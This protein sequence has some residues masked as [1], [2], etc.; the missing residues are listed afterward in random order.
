[1]K[2]HRIFTPGPTEVVPRV[3]EAM[4]RPIMHHRSGQF[5]DLHRR[6][7]DELKYVYRTANPIVVLTASG[8]GAMEATIASLTLPGERVLV[9]RCGKFSARWA[10]VAGVY[11][12]DV[13][14]LD[15]PWG[16]TIAAERLEEALEESGD[17]A[18]VFT[19]HCE[20]STGVLMDVEGIAAASRR[21]GAM[22]VVDAITGLCAEEL[23]TDS[24][25]LDVVIGGSQKGFGVPPGLSFVS[26]SARARERLER[27]AH[28]VYYLDLGKALESQEKWDTPYTPSTVLFVALS[29]SLAMIRSEGL[30]NTVRRHGRNAAAVRS[31]VKALGLEL[32]ASVPANAVTT[33]LPPE[34]MAGRIA[35]TMA[36][37]YGIRIAQGQ[38]E[39]RGK[40]IRLGHL[41]FYDETDMLT[42]ISAL[43][44][45]L[46]AL[47][48]IPSLGAGLEALQESFARE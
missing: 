19:T 35:E 9:T 5:R 24:W 22:V 4:S 44:G 41:G 16:E 27:A 6:I 3:R 20:T 31:A 39:L 8:T 25:G 38:G 26:L 42:L 13:V 28:P 43:E 7:V 2:K 46:H 33:V 15:A 1:M 36:K 17:V 48:I 32:F 40:I 21:R 34:G 18:A 30:E 12:L 45:T 10:E 47:G 37:R 11:G 14:T 29:E 23:S